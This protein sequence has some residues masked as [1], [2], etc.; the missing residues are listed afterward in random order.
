MALEVTVCGVIGACV[1]IICTC[2]EYCTMMAD[3]VVNY[4]ESVVRGHL[5]F[6]KA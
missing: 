3:L 6:K 5:V 4:K 2:T 1:G